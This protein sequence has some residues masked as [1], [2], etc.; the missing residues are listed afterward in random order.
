VLTLSLCGLWQ[1]GLFDDSV[2]VS[3][4]W[5][6]SI[7][8]AV[9]IA[10][11][12]LAA[13][14]GQMLMSTGLRSSQDQEPV[15]WEVEESW[16]S[17]ETPLWRHSDELDPEQVRDSTPFVHRTADRLSV[18][19]RLAILFVV[20]LG[21]FVCSYLDSKLPDE[22]RIEFLEA[23]GL[24]G[25]LGLLPLFIIVLGLFIILIA[26]RRNRHQRGQR[27]PGVDYLWDK[28]VEEPPVP[29]DIPDWVRQLAPPEVG[30]GM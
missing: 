28:V 21:F 6:I 12:L 2:G 24:K 4:V 1:F 27:R 29:A 25:L 10:S 16:S 11:I 8:V 17:K 9:V 13:I 18:V 30:R 15:S 19:W 26:G 22:F 5:G 7:V 23:L 3:L 20:L 14:L